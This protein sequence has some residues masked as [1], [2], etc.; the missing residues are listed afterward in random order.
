MVVFEFVMLHFTSPFVESFIF[1]KFA[2]V[3][4]IWESICGKEIE[5]FLILNVGEVHSRLF[6]PKNISGL[7]RLHSGNQIFINVYVD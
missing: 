6:P 2:V 1:F 4:M 5:N 7:S 3:D